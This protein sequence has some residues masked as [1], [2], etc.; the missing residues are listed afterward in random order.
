M[1]RSHLQ[2]ATG[3]V[4]C[5]GKEEQRGIAALLAELPGHETCIVNAPTGAGYPIL[6]NESGQPTKADTPI[7]QP[8]PNGTLPV[9]YQ[10]AANAPG[11]VLIV[12]DWHRLANSPMQW[13]ALLDALPAIRSPRGASAT[14]SASL[15]VFVAP[16]L[17]LQPDNPLRGMI[18]LLELDPPDREALHAAASS[19]VELNGNTEGILDALCGLTAEQ[20]QQAC[21]E[22]YVRCNGHLEVD[23]LRQYQRQ[24]LRDGGLEL[25][26][27]NEEL[28]G[29][30][31]L[32]RA[33]ENEVIPWVR[34]ET[35][36]VRRILCAGVPGVGKSYFASWLASRLNC[37]CARLSIP[38]L[39]AGIVGSSEANLRRCLKTIDAMSSHAPLVVVLDE[40]D[41]VA[42]EGADGGTSSGMFAELLTW[43]QMS[44]SQAVV[45]ATLNHLEK[46]DAALESRFQMRFYFELPSHDERKA[47]ASIHYRRVGCI[48][49]QDAA[50]FT[51]RLTDGYSSREIAEQIVPS[52]SRLSRREPTNRIIEMV[53]RD[54]VPASRTQGPQLAAMR[55]AAQTL[56]RA[57]DDTDTA[58]PHPSRRISA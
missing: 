43:L 12:M 37:E 29:C 20:A 38:A 36:S 22:T 18:P 31:G 48:N 54:T 27:R 5:V 32:K 35:L 41:S 46:L 50:E 9:A 13:R 10:W 7:I 40:I 58:D 15:V 6:L 42:R 16:S 25:W 45:V 23:L 11:R 34:D 8:S 24:A 3:A 4:A 47:V 49:V 56:R 51:A 57:N 21:A 30:G 17:D 53:I 19:V 1:F 2:A 44:K 26:P 28:G 39:K 55:Q 33:I 14:D 52:V